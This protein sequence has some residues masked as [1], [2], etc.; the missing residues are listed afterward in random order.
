MPRVKSPETENNILKAAIECFS[1][2]GFTKTT[3]SSIAKKAGISH[4]TVF[5]YF[6]SKEDLFEKAV[7]GPQHWFYEKQVGLIQS[8]TGNSLEQLS[9]MVHLHVDFY[10]KQADY[11]RLVQYVFGQKERFRSIVNQ[12]YSYTDQYIDVLEEVVKK[13]QEEGMIHNDQ[14]RLT[15][16]SYFSFLNGISLTFNENVSSEQMNQFKVSAERILGIGMRT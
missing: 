7:I 6:S 12:I 2:E 15:C 8:T 13:V 9:Q 14:V 1:Q 10:M 3:I 5:L 4:A 11:L 16:W